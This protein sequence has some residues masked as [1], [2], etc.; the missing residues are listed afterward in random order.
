MAIFARV[1]ASW[2]TELTPSMAS[3]LLNRSSACREGEGE[4][5]GRGGKRKGGEGREERGCN[6]P[7]QWGYSDLWRLS[8]VGR[9]V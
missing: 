6:G 4:G 8:A 3:I 5:G 2:A 1:A 9:Y 7:V